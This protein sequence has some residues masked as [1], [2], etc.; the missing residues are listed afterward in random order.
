MP[1]GGK[2]P[3]SGRKLGSH[4]PKTLEKLE[5]REALR[6]HLTAKMLTVAE[7]L[8]GRAVGIRYFV[9]RNKTTGKFELVTNPEQVVKALNRED[10][11]SGEFYTDKPET[12]AIK[13]F[14]D[15]TVDKS[16]EP[17]QQLDI[18]GEISLVDTLKAARARHAKRRS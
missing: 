10:D 3:G 13:E 8:V 16:Q 9:T 18:T 14:F 15:R 11:E 6:R 5:A 4:L 17:P 7:A 1:N 2:R 12:A